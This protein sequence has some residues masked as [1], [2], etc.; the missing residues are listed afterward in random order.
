MGI[1]GSD[2][3]RRTERRH[4][5]GVAPSVVAHAGSSLMLP[6]LN[7]DAIAVEYP[8]NS[9]RERIVRGLPK[10][11]MDRAEALSEA[12]RAGTQV[13]EGV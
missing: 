13:G 12:R 3:P 1:I 9:R 6:N 4:D 2:V 7:C 11:I 10:R 8:S 5:V